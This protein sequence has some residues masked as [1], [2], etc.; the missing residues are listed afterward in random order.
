M[1][2]RP[3]YL[4][5]TWLLVIIVLLATPL[6]LADIWMMRGLDASDPPELRLLILF[7]TS[8]VYLLPA[9]FSLGLII[10]RVIDHQQARRRDADT[11]TTSR[12]VMSLGRAAGIIFWLAVLAIPILAMIFFSVLFFPK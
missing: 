8:V 6:G 7:T 12:D 4:V 3:Q 9:W 1:A 11:A 5:P 2:E 10:R